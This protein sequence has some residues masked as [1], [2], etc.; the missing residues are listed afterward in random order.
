MEMGHFAGS[1]RVFLKSET[2]QALSTQALNPT[3]S[4]CAAA[5]PLLVQPFVPLHLHTSLLT[6]VPSLTPYPP[7]LPSP[8]LPSFPLPYPFSPPPPPSPCS[9]YFLS[10]PHPFPPPTPLPYC[11]LILPLIH[12]TLHSSQAFHAANTP[13]VSCSSSLSSIPLP[14]TLPAHLSRALTSSNCYGFS[15]EV[16]QCCLGAGIT[17]LYKWHAYVTMLTRLFPINGTSVVQ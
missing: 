9:I 11:H 3:P 17:L 15:T 2:T 7:P 13:I 5:P 16:S 14:P 6:P 8:P 10:P 1:E 12:P 4:Q